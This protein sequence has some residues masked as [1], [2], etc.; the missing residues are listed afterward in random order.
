MKCKLKNDFE[1]MNTFFDAILIVSDRKPN[2]KHLNLEIADVKEK[3]GI[4]VDNYL[5]TSNK[6]FYAV[7][8]CI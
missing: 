5:K 6:C 4:I 1:Y 2:L 3:D 7:G 8:S